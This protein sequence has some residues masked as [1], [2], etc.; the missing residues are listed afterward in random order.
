[1]ANCNER[2]YILPENICTIS[3]GRPGKKVCILGGVHGNETAG[4]VAVKELS[5]ELK[6]DAGE[7]LL[8]T[9]NDRAILKKK[10]FI[11][12]NLNRCFRRYRRRTGS[13]EEGIARELKGILRKQD[14]CIDI[15][16]SN[17]PGSDPFIICERN[18]GP[19]LAS[20]PVRKVVSGFDDIEPGG[21][22]YYMNQQGKIGVCIECG[23]AKDESSVSFAK[24]A[25][26]NILN[27]TGNIRQDWKRNYTKA[28]FRLFKAYIPKKRFTLAKRF[29]DFEI[30][31]KGQ[32]IGTDGN[33]KIEAEHNCRILFA[34]DINKSKD[35]QG[36]AFLLIKRYINKNR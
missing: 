34:K 18:A 36:E 6:I 5:R 22:D 19:I 21:T 31:R 8:V 27:R 29:L 17:T 30:L 1:M 25:I 33:R 24:E 16:N 12:E 10:R 4:I 11:D 15:H 20:I 13:Y 14:I 7:V 23:Y 28:M 35:A 2:P 3:S 32:T 9:C 26:I